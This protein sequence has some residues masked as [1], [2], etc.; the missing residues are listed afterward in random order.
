[1]R[2]QG[3]PASMAAALLIGLAQTYLLI[4]CWAFIGMYTPLPRWLIESGVTGS[5][6]RSILFVLDFAVSVLLCVPAAYLL[7]KLRPSKPWIYLALAVMPG[8]IW[9]YRLVLGDAVLLRDWALFLPGA[10]AALFMLPVAT[11][12]VHRVTSR[13]A[14]NNS[15]KPKPLRGSA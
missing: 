13:G 15:F 7:C 3:L 9:Q 5:T 1:M 2:L 14:P 8:F 10:L 4:M 6:L 11:L 12:I